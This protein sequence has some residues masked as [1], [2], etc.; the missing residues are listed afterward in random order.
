MRS[1]GVSAE[2]GERVEARLHRDTFFELH[3]HRYL[4]LRKSLSMSSCWLVEIQ[5]FEIEDLLRWM[6]KLR[7]QCCK[8]ELM[9]ASSSSE[10]ETWRSIMVL[11]IGILI[12]LE[13][14]SRRG[15]R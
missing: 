7:M 2:K 4:K 12:T 9:R 6:K 15:S 1:T 13:L 10:E 8:Y 5:G 3:G 11:Y 14:R